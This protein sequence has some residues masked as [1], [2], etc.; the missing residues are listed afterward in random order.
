M[1][2]QSGNESLTEFGGW[3]WPEWCHF[4][5]QLSHMSVYILWQSNTN[6]YERLA[7]TSP[8]RNITDITVLQELVNNKTWLVSSPVPQHAGRF[9]TI[10]HYKFSRLALSVLRLLTIVMSRLHT[11]VSIMTQSSDNSPGQKITSASRL[12]ENLVANTLNNL[13]L[14]TQMLLTVPVPNIPTCLLSRVN[15]SCIAG[16][17]GCIIALSDIDFNC[18]PFTINIVKSI[19]Q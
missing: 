19:S 14:T 17:F 16:G 5:K 7:N 3:P 12:R 11:V 10:F 13:C 9:S 18:R 15:G 2:P 8:S 1:A 4:L 6:I